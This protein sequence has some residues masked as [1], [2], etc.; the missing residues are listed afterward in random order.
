MSRYL[1]T[2]DRCFVRPDEI[3]RVTQSGLHI[4]QD[5]EQDRL[6]V[7]IALG[8]GPVTA[9]GVRLPHYVTVGDHVVFSPDAGEELFFERDRIIVMREADILAIIQ[10]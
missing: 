7:V 4:V 1:V 9:K 8:D 6:G 5:R 2:G 10:E 3:V